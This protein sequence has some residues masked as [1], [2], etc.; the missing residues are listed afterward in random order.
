[1]ASPLRP[2]FRCTVMRKAVALVGLLVAA[3]SQPGQ[4]TEKGIDL[5][6]DAIG[7]QK[8]SD[9]PGCPANGCF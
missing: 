4:H 5:Y 1:M 2:V 8:V 7:L 6:T 9:Q 3:C